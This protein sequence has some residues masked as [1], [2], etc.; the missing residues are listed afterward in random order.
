MS[1]QGS[2]ESRLYLNKSNIHKVEPPILSIDYGTKNIGLAITDKKGIVAQPLTTIKVKD[3]NYEKFFSK[4]S[5]IIK[6]YEIE[7]L[8]LGIPQ[9][10]KEDH[11]QNMN[12]ILEFR[13]SIKKMTGREVFLYDESYST[14]DSYS[15]LRAQGQSQKKSRQKIDKIAASRFLQELVDFKNR[16]NE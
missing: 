4:L 5:K 13:S 9:T 3:N 16:K 11:L 15:M 7:T 6:D 8:V 12:R 14:S 10:F 2:K 1:E